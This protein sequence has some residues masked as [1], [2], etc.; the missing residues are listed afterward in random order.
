MG[1]FMSAIGVAVSAGI[2]LILRSRVPNSNRYTMYIDPLISLFIAAVILIPTIPLVIRICKVLMQAA[3]EH[4][5][6]TQ[7]LSDMKAMEGVK[8]VQ[9]MHV[10]SMLRG[11][12]VVGSVHLVLHSAATATATGNGSSNSPAVDA[13]IQMQQVMRRA[14]KLF[15]SSGVQFCTVQVEFH[16]EEE[17]LLPSQL[18]ELHIDDAA[19]EEHVENAPLIDK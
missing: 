17:Q 7:L 3:P 5:N 6:V 18:E 12:K 2:V 11:D 1:D 15:Y 8:S 10:W 13:R 14:K 19:E 9:E 4:I 16:V